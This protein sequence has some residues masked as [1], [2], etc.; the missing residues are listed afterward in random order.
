[1]NPRGL[2]QR[3][4]AWW[5][6]FADAGGRIRREKAGTL[7]NAK[8]LYMLRKAA[9][10][11]GRKLPENLRVIV[12]VSDLVPA[13]RGDYRDK[14]QKSYDWVERRLRLHILPF[15][16]ELAADEVTT[17]HIRAY[18]DSREDEGATSASINRE[19]AVLKRMYNLGRAATPPKVR[20]VP[21][22]PRLKESDPRSGFVED[23]YYQTLVGQ[24]SELWLRAIIA[25]AYT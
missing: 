6:R 19:L 4:G 7:A 22:M 10:L 15:F 8:R 13:L 21:F 9:V 25:V 14:G 3:N 23:A 17:D 20:W 18:I 24:T 5:I 2:F 11:E 16:A 12:R 1:M